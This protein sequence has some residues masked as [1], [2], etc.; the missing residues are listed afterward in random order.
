METKVTKDGFV[1]LVVTKEL[2]KKIYHDIELFM[3]HDDDSESKVET[4]KDL[5]NNNPIGIPVHF[6]NVLLA[7]QYKA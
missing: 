3:L 1:W 6:I 7:K 5:D 2:A 4:I